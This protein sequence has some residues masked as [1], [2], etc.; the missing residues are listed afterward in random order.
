MIFSLGLSSLK[1]RYTQ[2]STAKRYTRGLV[3]ERHWKK[4]DSKEF[5]VHTY[6]ESILYGL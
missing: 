2:P 3:K 1:P 4:I 5:V 6:F